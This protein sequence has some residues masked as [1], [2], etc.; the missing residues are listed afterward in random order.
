MLDEGTYKTTIQNMNNI[1]WKE[2]LFKCA[3][4]MMLGHGCG[5]SQYPQFYD[6]IKRNQMLPHQYVIRYIGERGHQFLQ[7]P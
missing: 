5:A 3:D 2:K 4:D 6:R 7:E 1:F